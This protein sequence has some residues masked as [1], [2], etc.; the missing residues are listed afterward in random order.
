MPLQELIYTSLSK[1]P[2][3]PLAINQDGEVKSILAESNQNN[4]QAGI[5]GLLMFDGVRFI[6]ILEGEA[7]KV[8]DLYGKIAQDSRHRMIELLHKGSLATRSFK[9]WRMAYEAIPPDLLGHLAENIAV[10]SMELNGA[11]LPNGESFGEKMNVMFM[12]AMAAE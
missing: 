5:T 3:D 1:T 9:D 12:D 10:S 6:Q 7:D 11:P 8:D 2:S 4:S